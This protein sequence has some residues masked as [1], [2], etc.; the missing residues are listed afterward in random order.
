MSSLHKVKLDMCSF[1]FGVRKE[2][3]G[4]GIADRPLCSLRLG[5]IY[6]KFHAE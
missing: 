1:P 6:E 2:R 5:N 3:V 4:F